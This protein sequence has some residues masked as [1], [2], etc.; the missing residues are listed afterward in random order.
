MGSP[1][2]VW[3]WVVQLLMVLLGPVIALGII[4]SVLNTQDTL[5]PQFLGYVF[6]AVVATGLASTVF[7][8]NPH[9]AKSGSR[10]WVLPI[11]LEVWAVISEL[12]SLGG[13][14]GGIFLI[15]GPGRGEEGLG[16]LITLQTWS[17]SWYSAAMWWRLRR[18]RRHQPSTN[19]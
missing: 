4:E 13:S 12:S 9:W 14:V 6:L 18:R 11:A 1:L 15:P 5:I 19:I 10:I 17:C 2:N 7:A 8:L 3:S 16:V